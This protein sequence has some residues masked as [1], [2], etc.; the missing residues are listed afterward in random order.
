MTKS[1]RRSARRCPA[2]AQEPRSSSVAACRGQVLVGHYRA[3][4]GFAELLQARGRD[5]D[6]VP[7]PADVLRDPEKTA[8]A[9]LLEVEIK[10]FT[11]Y[12]HAFAKYLRV[13]APALQY[14]FEISPVQ[15]NAILNKNASIFISYHGFPKDPNGFYLIGPNGP[16]RKPGRARRTAARLQKTMAYLPQGRRGAEGWFACPLVLFVLELGHWTFMLNIGYSPENSKI[17]DP[18]FDT[19][20]DSDSD[21]D[22]DPFSPRPSSSNLDIGHS[23]WILDILLKTLNPPLSLRDLCDLCGDSPYLLFPIPSLLSPI[24]YPCFSLSVA[25]GCGTLNICRPITGRHSRTLRHEHVF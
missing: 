4:N 1:E 22:D 25:R 19:D 12:L 14:R 10:G 8:A 24:P 21:S 18:D 9:V 2:R 7:V 16:S 5:N 20:T 11:L 23:C 15:E 13:Q 17:H 3:L 6:R